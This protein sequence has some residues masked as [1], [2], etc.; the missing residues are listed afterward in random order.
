MFPEKIAWDVPSTVLVR[1]LAKSSLPNVG[2]HVRL[3]HQMHK[4]EN[5]MKMKS[6]KSRGGVRVHT[7]RMTNYCKLVL[8]IP[9]TSHPRIS[10]WRRLNAS[11]HSFHVYQIANMLT[12]HLR[13]VYIQFLAYDE[14]YNDINENSEL[15]AKLQMLFFVGNMHINY[16]LLNG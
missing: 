13:T 2:D 4:E 15:H 12:F 6:W 1:S 9:L 8:L 14:F 11:F 3:K 5:S 16:F 10:S 7:D